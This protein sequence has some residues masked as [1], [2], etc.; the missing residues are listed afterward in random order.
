MFL[1]LIKKSLKIDFNYYD[2]KIVKKWAQYETSE[3]LLRK[4]LG[5][6]QYFIAKTS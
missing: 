6:D 2:Y 5:N 1:R 4:R 3:W